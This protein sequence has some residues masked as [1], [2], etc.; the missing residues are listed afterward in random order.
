MNRSI[1]VVRGVS[2]G[3]LKIGTSYVPANRLRAV[4][5]ASGEAVEVIAVVP[6]CGPRLSGE[7]ALHRRFASLLAADSGR[8]REWFRDD[9]SIAEWVAGLPAAQR[10]SFRVECQRQGARRG[11]FFEQRP[12]WPS[13]IAG[14][15]TTTSPDGAA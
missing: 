1:Y 10:G 4:A 14:A 7:R 3:L 8:G 9:G 13:F 15:I 11:R 12:A 5:N 6:T 2:S